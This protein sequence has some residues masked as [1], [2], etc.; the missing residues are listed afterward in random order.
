MSRTLASRLLWVYNGAGRSCIQA[1]QGCRFHDGP[2]G[3]GSQG[4][5]SVVAPDVGGLTRSEALRAS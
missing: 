3:T 5:T 1:D 2:A 4:F